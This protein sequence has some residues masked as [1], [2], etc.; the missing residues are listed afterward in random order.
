MEHVIL[1]VEGCIARGYGSC[2]D[3]AASILAACLVQGLDAWLCV[4]DPRVPTVPRNYAHVRV[5]VDGQWAFDP[6]SSKRPRGLPES[7]RREFYV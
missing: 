1:D 4:E 7:C 5:I 6:Y 3:A 2:G